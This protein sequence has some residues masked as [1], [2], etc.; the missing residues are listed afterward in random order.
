MLCED[1]HESE[2]EV[3]VTEVDSSGNLKEK[4]LCKVCAS[5]K[6]YILQKQKPLVELFADF[7]KERGETDDK[8]LTCSGCGMSWAEF[9]QT[10]RFGCAECYLKFGERIERLI[11][12][13]QGTTH[14]TGRKAPRE[15]ED[16]PVFRQ[17]Q[18]KRL[19]RELAKA[20]QAE[21]YEKAARLRDDLRKFEER[22]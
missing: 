4:H 17:M 7:L 3:L 20:I 10:G 12:R 14:H 21:E 8:E 5:K 6:G 15:P 13:I 9:K 18:M 16:S 22:P 11:A 19:R 2:A 1:C